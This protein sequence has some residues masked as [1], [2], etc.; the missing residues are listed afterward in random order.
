[1]EHEIAAVAERLL[2][3]PRDWYSAQ[4][5]NQLMLAEEP[6]D[7]LYWLVH[8]CND[9]EP[10]KTI[11]Q[12]ADVLALTAQHQ[13]RYQIEDDE[14]VT[15]YAQGLW[16]EDGTFTVELAIITAGNAYN[17]RIG[18]SAEPDRLS[19]APDAPIPDA[20]ALTLAQAYEVLAGWASG[21]GLPEGYGGTIHTYR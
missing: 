17:M 21:R 14:P 4:E 18:A 15:K 9:W 20:Q 3:T 5:L 1:M 19:S 2:A 6:V 13:S 16:L 12:I 10:L 11:A 7:E 8:D